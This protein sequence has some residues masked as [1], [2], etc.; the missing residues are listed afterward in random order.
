M[1]VCSFSLNKEITNT[2]LIS[3]CPFF[4]YLNKNNIATLKITPLWSLELEDKPCLSYWRENPDL[5]LR[6]FS[7]VCSFQKGHMMIH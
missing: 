2:A 4:V 1:Q 6:L 3:G 7:G 5:R